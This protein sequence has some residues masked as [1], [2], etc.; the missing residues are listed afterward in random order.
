MKQMFLIRSYEKDDLEKLFKVIH[1]SVQ[2][3][4][5]GVYSQEQ[6][7]TWIA[8]DE[9][10]A[11]RQNS[12]FTHNHTLVAEVMGEPVGFASLYPEQ[13]HI[14][15][16]CVMPHDEYAP[17][18]Q[19][20]LSAME[21]YVK[22]LDLQQITIQTPL[23]TEAFFKSQNFTVIETENLPIISLDIPMLIMI[24]KL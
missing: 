5:G 22:K 24:K 1:A 7:D 23:P 19:A 10:D 12:S 20:L 6:I 8:Y 2:S 4:L 9:S 11:V 17:I 18:V 14:Q 16:L 3:L 13:G 15:R 21:T